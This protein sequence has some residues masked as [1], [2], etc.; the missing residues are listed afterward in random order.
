MNYLILIR[1][2]QSKWNLEKRFTGW[3]DIDLTENGILEAKK[4]GALI[5]KK[6]LSIDF[7]YSSRTHKSKYNYSF[8]KDASKIAKISV[9]EQVINVLPP[10]FLPFSKNLFK[11]SLLKE[12]I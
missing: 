8:E 6:N 9:F 2:G 5:K 4:A 11:S 10:I 3:V 7:Y 1:H 12:L